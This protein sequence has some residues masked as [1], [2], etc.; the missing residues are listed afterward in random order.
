M[1][2]FFICELSKEDIAFL[3]AV[4]DK[5][6]YNLFK[7]RRQQPTALIYGF[8][9]QLLTK[10]DFIN[11][12]GVI[13]FAQIN[14]TYLKN[15]AFDSHDSDSQC[16]ALAVLKLMGITI[17]ESGMTYGT[18][19]S[20]DFIDSTEE[21][22]KFLDRKTDDVK[23]AIKNCYIIRINVNS[24]LRSLYKNTKDFFFNEDNSCKK[25]KFIILE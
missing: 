5:D 15:L 1:E 9:G 7:L 8:I 24:T 25:N 13:I 6:Y 21:W 20:Q 2:P 10:A 22:I 17:S 3:K 11:T 19:G 16:I 12:I 14:I 23:E 4:Q 18:Y